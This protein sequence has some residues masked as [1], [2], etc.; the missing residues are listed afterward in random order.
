MIGQD[1]RQFFFK[2]IEELNKISLDLQATSCSGIEVKL[3]VG[4][5]YTFNGV[6]DVV[7]AQQYRWTATNQQWDIC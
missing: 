6:V 4:Y 7:D 3:K 5:E 1:Q 2:P